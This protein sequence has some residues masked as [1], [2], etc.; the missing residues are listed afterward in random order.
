MTKKPV[1]RSG[2]GESHPTG[3]KHSALGFRISPEMNKVAC[4]RSPASI[5]VM[6][7]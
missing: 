6:V 3:N 5:V 4:E 7:V 1:I 2:R